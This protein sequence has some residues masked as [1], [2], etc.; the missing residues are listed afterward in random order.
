MKIAVIGSSV[1]WGAWD[2]EYH[3]WVNRLQLQSQDHIWINLSVSGDTL[4]NAQSRILSELA[5]RHVDGVILALGSNDCVF[6]EGVERRK[7]EEFQTDICTTLQSLNLTYKYVAVL[8]IQNIDETKVGMK[9][10]KKS[11]RTNER[12]NMFNDILASASKQYNVLF[13]S[14]KGILQ[15]EDLPDGLHPNALGH[16]KI[17]DQVNTVLGDYIDDNK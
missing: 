17:A 3:G 10:S 11:K 5:Y 6:R 9:S 4:E 1:A 7:I 8:G 14:L 13:I 16:Q 15:N 2:L 12:V